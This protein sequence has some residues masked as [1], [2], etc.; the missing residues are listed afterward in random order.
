MGTDHSR[1]VAGNVV[2]LTM[3][4]G[5]V[6]D[7]KKMNK[8]AEFFEEIATGV[9]SLANERDYSLGIMVCASLGGGVVHEK[10]ISLN[11]SF[12]LIGVLRTWRPLSR[13]GPGARW[14]MSRSGAAAR[15]SCSNVAGDRTLG[16]SVP[17]E[18]R[19]GSEKA[20]SDVAW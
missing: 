16:H 8:S 4:C 19:K 15:T 14:W 10:E 13:S 20:H 7:K 2:C 17:R 18:S 6:Q 11:S 12:A 3:V 9:Q 1:V 5:A